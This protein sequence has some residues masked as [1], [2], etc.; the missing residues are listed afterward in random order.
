MDRHYLCFGS[1]TLIKPFV[2]LKL[3]A[4]GPRYISV[5]EAARPMYFSGHG[6][7]GLVALL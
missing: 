7:S 6:N 1:S 2:W 5:T 3:I 4:L